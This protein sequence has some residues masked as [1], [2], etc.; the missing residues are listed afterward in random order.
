[1]S[2]QPKAAQI[3]IYIEGGGSDK[4]L[5]APMREGFGAFFQEIKQKVSL[6]VIMCGGNKQALEDFRAAQKQHTD[7]FNVLLMD[8]DHPVQPGHN[9]KQHIATHHSDWELP[10][11]SDDQYHLMTQIMEAWFLADRK[12]LLD[13]YGSG[14]RESALPANPNVE[15]VAKEDIYRGLEA[16]SKETSKKE[17][18][19]RLHGADILKHLDRH[20]VCADNH[21]PHCSRLF[22]VLESH[23]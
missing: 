20:R 17:Y 9:S 7:S 5:Q 13:F 19:K 21:A 10:P 12:A 4:A 11:A 18:Q 2:P 23:C 15:Q 8:S 14:F 3:R 1:L 16:A 22:E 6:K